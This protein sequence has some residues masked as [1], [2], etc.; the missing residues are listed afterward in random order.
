MPLLERLGSRA[1]VEVGTGVEHLDLVEVLLE[2][3]GRHERPEVI[4]VRHSSAV[5]PQPPRPGRGGVLGNTAQTHYMEVPTET[6][7]YGDGPEQ[8]GEL[9]LPKGGED[10]PLVTLL[11][12]G[13]WR[14]QYRLDLMRPLADALAAKGYASWNVEYRRVGPT[15]GGFPT[16]LDDVAAAIDRAVTLAAA[17]WSSLAVIGHS[18]GGHLALWNAS[19]TGAA[20]LPALTVGLAPVAD[21][22]AANRRGVGRDATANFFGGNID[23]VPDRYAVGQPDPDGFAGRVVLLHGDDDDSVPL[24]QSES[25]ADAVDRLEVLAGA[26]HFDVI[27]PTHASW[28]IVFDEL[29][30]LYV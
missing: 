9:M 20:W 28:K 6:I 14:D 30:E 22:I 13:F 5:V 10:R 2:P 23:D 17:N 8:F 12:G 25:I 11:H 4:H 1:P 24:W 3:D 18:A 19:R 27:D 21:V 7:A 15:G 29:D 16:T 26:D